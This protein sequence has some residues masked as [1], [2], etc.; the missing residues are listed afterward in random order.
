MTGVHDARISISDSLLRGESLPKEALDTRVTVPLA[1]VIVQ[2]AASSAERN[3][4]QPNSGSDGSSCM[5]LSTSARTKLTQ[6]NS[7][8]HVSCPPGSCKRTKRPDA[9]SSSSSSVLP[10]LTSTENAN[11]YIANFCGAGT[12]SR[13]ISWRGV[14]ARN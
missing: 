3:Q 2:P 7:P 10:L 5:A 11:E 14:N 6:R 1:A 4:P 12:S 8:S 13:I 9:S